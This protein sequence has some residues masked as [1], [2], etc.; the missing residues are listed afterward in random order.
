MV[1]LKLYKNWKWNVGKWWKSE[2]QILENEIENIKIDNTKE[3]I[4]KYFKI[5]KDIYD[6]KNEITKL[7]WQ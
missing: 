1:L 7:T 5:Y 4:E 2:K 6:P 3:Y